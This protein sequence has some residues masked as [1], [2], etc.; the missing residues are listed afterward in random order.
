M[1]ETPLMNDEAARSATGEII[2]QATAKP[3][4]TTQTT[5]PS[6]PAAEIPTATTE[7]KPAT[8]TTK[9][10]TK[11]ETKPAVPETYE[12]KAPEGYTIDPKLLETAAP[13]FKELGLTNDQAQK[14]VDI[15]IAREIAA[16][17]GPADSYAATRTEWQNAVK[18]DPEISAAG[19]DRVKTDIGRVIATLPT[20]LQGDFRKA[21]DITGAGDHPAMVKALWK[22]SSLVTEGSHV[23]GKGPSSEGQRAPGT[24]AKPSPAAALYPKL[25]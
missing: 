11:D 12:F 23:T 24:A 25:A 21:M 13:I 17:K 20:D 16:A 7:T 14:L 22:L 18:A 6:T 3:A 5:T 9:D 2:D 8:E 1:S 15:Q 4:E 10:T 19:L